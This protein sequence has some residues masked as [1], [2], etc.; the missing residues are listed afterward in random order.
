[1]YAKENKKKDELYSKIKDIE[2]KVK[3]NQQCVICYDEPENPCYTKCCNTKYCL[4]CLTEVMKVNNSNTQAKCPYCRENITN[5][6]ML[7][8]NDAGPKEPIQQPI[9]NE[10]KDKYEEFT[11]LLV[12]L[13]EDTT[14]K[15]KILIF[16]ERF[17]RNSRLSKFGLKIFFSESPYQN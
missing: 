13:A 12:K 6:T 1:M 2:E 8:L 15:H 10:K 3:E 14:N 4:E 5:D 9:V 16:K 17:A 7:I 11:I